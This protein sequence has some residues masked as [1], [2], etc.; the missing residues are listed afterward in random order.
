MP[1]LAYDVDLDGAYE[2]RVAVLV[3][4]PP[5]LLARESYTL[6]WGDA[7]QSKPAAHGM[8]ETCLFSAPAAGR[9]VYGAAVLGRIAACTYGIARVSNATVRPSPDVAE[10]PRRAE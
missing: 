4:E 1:T 8:A 7:A 5:T 2:G 9:V 6:L 3:D 10:G